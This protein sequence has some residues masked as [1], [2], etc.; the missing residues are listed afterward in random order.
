MKNKT[1]LTLSLIL[2]SGLIISS[3]YAGDKCEGPRGN[4]PHPRF[5]RGGHRGGPD[6]YMSPEQYAKIFD[7]LD[8]MEPGIKDLFTELKESD[9]PEI[10]KH[11]MGLTRD[12][13][14]RFMGRRK[15][16]DTKALFAKS[17]KLELESLKLSDEVMSCTDEA[18]KESLKNALKSKLNESFD[19][20]TELRS[21]H[22]TRMAEKLEEIKTQ[23]EERKSNK[24][25]IVEKRLNEL[26]EK[27][28][29]LD[30]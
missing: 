5:E 15:A 17:L 10:K 16:S 12:H 4:G 1:F 28:G 6:E 3:A 22:I 27:Q 20:K 25:Q 13:S 8:E 30:W 11:I 2:L 21:S 23:N 7:E 19:A 9:N 24:D 26:V 14:F 29:N 18:E